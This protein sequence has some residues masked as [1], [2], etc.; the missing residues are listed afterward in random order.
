MRRVVRCAAWLVIVAV[1]AGCEVEK[2]PPPWGAEDGQADS[3]EVRVEEVPDG[4]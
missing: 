2:V 1:L 3:L 4:P